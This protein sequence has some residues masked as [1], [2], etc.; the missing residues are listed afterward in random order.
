MRKIPLFVL[1]HDINNAIDI[2]TW[3]PF[4][5]GRELHEILDDY[6]KNCATFFENQFKSNA[7]S[8][9]IREIFPQLQLTSDLVNKFKFELFNSFYNI[10]LMDVKS[11]RLNQEEL[12]KLRDLLP[13]PK[14][15]S[16]IQ[17][18]ETNSNELSGIFGTGWFQY[19]RVQTDLELRKILCKNYCRI[20]GDTLDKMA[21]SSTGDSLKSGKFHFHEWTSELRAGATVVQ[22]IT[23]ILNLSDDQ[24]LDLAGKLAS[25]NQNSLEPLYKYTDQLG[26]SRYDVRKVLLS[27]IDHTDSRNRIALKIA[28]DYE[29]DY[30]TVESNNFE[31]LHDKALAFKLTD[32]SDKAVDVLIKAS[33]TKIPAISKC[34]MGY[35]V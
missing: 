8:F 26:L 17:I 19:H 34:T 18:D 30:E 24:R 13:R 27:G 12:L 32:Q 3:V 25:P 14:L 33:K 5:G 21:E 10:F 15:Y 31:Y 7:L 20:Y 35:R 11:M 16:I 1:T 28:N 29:N 6:N 22:H 2:P 4:S 9:Y 23:G